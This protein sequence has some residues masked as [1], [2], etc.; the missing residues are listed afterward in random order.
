MTTPQIS[1][2]VQ[3][4]HCNDSLLPHRGELEVY[5]FNVNSV[6]AQNTIHTP[7]ETFKNKM[8][9][10]WINGIM[11]AEMLTWA[12]S[13]TSE[14]FLKATSPFKNCQACTLRL[15]NERSQGFPGD[16]EDMT[17]SCW[18]YLW[19]SRHDPISDFTNEWTG[20]WILTIY[21]DNA[22]KSAHDRDFKSLWDVKTLKRIRVRSRFTVLPPVSALGN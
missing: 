14:N 6:Y 17:L 7:Q 4:K 15:I 11:P 3:G 12:I 19:S 22:H 1:W 10:V 20:L 18:Q 8:Q 5:K 13:K 9:F 2:V 21:V 16:I